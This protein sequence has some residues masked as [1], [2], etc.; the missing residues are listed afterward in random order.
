MS[1]ERVV[2]GDILTAMNEGMDG[3]GLFRV[4]VFVE[5]VKTGD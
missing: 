3:V 2:V 5:V 4:V 1:Y